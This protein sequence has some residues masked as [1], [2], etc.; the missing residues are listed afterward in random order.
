MHLHLIHP[1]WRCDTSTS[2]RLGHVQNSTVKLLFHVTNNLNFSLIEVL[3][4]DLL[5][6]TPLYLCM[7]HEYVCG[8]CFSVA[9]SR[10]D[11]RYLD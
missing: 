4:S 7:Y 3:M 1:D 9:T 8:S 10:G 6:I 5:C 11:R 2:I